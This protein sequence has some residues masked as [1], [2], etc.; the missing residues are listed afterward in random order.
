[1]YT[2]N[3]VSVLISADFAVIGISDMKPPRSMQNV[4]N[5]QRI[6]ILRGDFM[7]KIGKWSSRIWSTDGKGSDILLKTI[8]FD[9]LDVVKVIDHVP[10]DALTEQRIKNT[11]RAKQ[12]FED[13]AKQCPETIIALL[14]EQNNEKN[15]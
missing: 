14:K 7:S 11:N 9:G 13:I 8:C 4:E 15:K 1:M 3:K 2:Q 10:D 6:I 12:A 5:R